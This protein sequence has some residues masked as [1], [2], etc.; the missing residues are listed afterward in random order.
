M[1]PFLGIPLS[2]IWLSP[3]QLSVME[4]LVQKLKLVSFLFF[5]LFFSFLFFLFLFS[6]PSFFLFFPMIYFLFFFFFFQGRAV[7]LIF[8]IWSVSLVPYVVSQLV[9]IMESINKYEFTSYRVNYRYDHIVIIGQMSGQVFFFFLFSF[10][11]FI[12]CY[13]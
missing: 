7:I 9:S 8:L 5:F 13:F 11:F 6:F 1:L 4:I 10:L 2:I 3:L 12:L